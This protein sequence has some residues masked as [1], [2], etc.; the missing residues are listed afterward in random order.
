MVKKY[1]WVWEV[2]TQVDEG[3]VKNTFYIITEEIHAIK[4]APIAFEYINIID[5]YF[6]SI[7]IVGSA[8]NI[9]DLVQ[10][11]FDIEDSESPA[12]E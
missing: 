8:A 3:A 11:Q 5:L 7:R 6:F 2:V 10:C 9:K 4:A 12:H 1:H